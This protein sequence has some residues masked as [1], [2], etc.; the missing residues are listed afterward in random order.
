MGRTRV[1]P[2]ATLSLLALGGVAMLSPSQ[3]AERPGGLF[4]AQA[5]VELKAAWPGTMDS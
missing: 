4:E 3:I 1:I 2:W 5:W